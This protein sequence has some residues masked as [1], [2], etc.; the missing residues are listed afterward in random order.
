MPATRTRLAAATALALSAAAL[1]HATAHAAPP[2]RAVDFARDV[3]PIFAKNCVRCHGP[4]KAEGGLALD[5]RARA[6]TGGDGGPVLIPGK[7]AESR[8]FRYV[9]GL[10]E[11]TV[12]PPDGEE[13]PPAQVETL[14]A[15]IDQ[16]AKWPEGP[17]AARPSA[18][19]DHWAFRKP[20]RPAVPS[21]SNAA[22]P[23]NPID[24]FVLARL[25]KEGLA[26][27]P[28]ADRATLIRRVTL[29]L[30]GLPPSV[31]EVDAFL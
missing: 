22:W 20:V 23:R 19:G 3:R 5:S 6:F 29:D 25:E 10:D 31:E 4:K 18:A 2:S 1:L 28:E 11:E 15:W 17:T 24:R 14:R 27:S 12:M 30:T 21:V 13:L 26:P 16:G 8:L 7:S 9:A